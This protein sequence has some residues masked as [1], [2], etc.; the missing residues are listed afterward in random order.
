M[1]NLGYA[2]GGQ[3]GYAAD[4][5]SPDPDGRGL[6]RGNRAHSYQSHDHYAHVESHGHPIGAGVN[7]TWTGSDIYSEISQHCNL[8]DHVTPLV[9]RLA[10]PMRPDTDIDLAG[11]AA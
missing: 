5:L 4:N 11:A 3:A 2:L 6:V 7:A 10:D 1:P 9:L 8:D